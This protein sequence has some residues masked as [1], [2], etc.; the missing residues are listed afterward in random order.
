MPRPRGR[1]NMAENRRNDVGELAR[2]QLDLLGLT[3]HVN[4]F[5]F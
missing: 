5:D 2:D 3:D 4:D 1:K